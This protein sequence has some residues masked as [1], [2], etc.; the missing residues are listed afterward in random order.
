MPRPARPATLPAA[1]FPALLPALLSALLALP[2]LGQRVEAQAL[3]PPP[4]GEPQRWARLDGVAIEFDEQL[5]TWSE[6]GQIYTRVARQDPPQDD[7]DRER[8]MR[9]LTTYLIGQVIA[10]QGGSE[11][12]IP[13]DR[14]EATLEQRLEELRAPAG[15]LAY[16]EQLRAQGLDPL[17]ELGNTR[18]EAYRVAFEN[19]ATGRDGLGVER[20]RHDRF[21]RPSQLRAAYVLSKPVGRVQLQLIDVTAIGVGGLEAAKQLA[22]S[23]RSAILAGADFEE[24]Y[25]LYGSSFRSSGGVTQSLPL[26]EIGDPALRQFATGAGPKDL[27]PVLEYGLGGRI[28]GYRV[29]RVFR[30]E[31]PPPAP[32]FSDAASQRALRKR[33]Q[34]AMDL[35]RLDLA[36][37]SLSQRSHQWLD[38]PLRGRPAPEGAAPGAPAAPAGARP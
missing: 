19:V 25:E 14:L 12:D 10:Q 18:D 3:P 38:G 33:L 6:L 24:Q 22:E 5:V 8:L 26:D 34:E 35:R 21:V 2:L 1:R 28:E 15:P 13:K 23:V 16:G 20:P 9:D 29:A 32:A 4:T 17:L 11:L 7:A 31:E 27:S 37:R 36:R 30:R